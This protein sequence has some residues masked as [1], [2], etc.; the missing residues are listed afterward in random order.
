MSPQAWLFWLEQQPPLSRF[1][2]CCVLL[3]L[4]AAVIAYFA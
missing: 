1:C 3:I 4:G 2:H